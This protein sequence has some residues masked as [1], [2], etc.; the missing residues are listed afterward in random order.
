MYRLSPLF[1]MFLAGTLAVLT[2]WLLARAVL[3]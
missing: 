2:G 3:A 1:L